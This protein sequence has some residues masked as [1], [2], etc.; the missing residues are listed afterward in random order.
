MVTVDNW[1]AALRSYIGVK[2]LHQ[3]RT[4][5]GIDCAGL[6][7]AAGNDLSINTTAIL[8]SGY[9]HTPDP[10]LLKAQLHKHLT[11][12]PYNRLQHFARQVEVGDIIAF[13]AERKGCPRHLAVYTGCKD[14]QL[15]FIHAYAKRPRRV[16]EAAFDLGYWL[17]RIDSVYRVPELEK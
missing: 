7:A 16:I 8:V 6:L 4:R 11:P 2:Y 1:L 13:W 3:G 12:V 9:A 5:S 17:Q 14:G 15:I 10:M